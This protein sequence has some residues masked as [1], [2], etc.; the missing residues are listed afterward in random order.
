MIG[1]FGQL[2]EFRMYCARVI[3]RLVYI[4]REIFTNP[5]KSIA[6]FLSELTSRSP[7]LFK[8]V[9]ISSGSDVRPCVS[10]ANVSMSGD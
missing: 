10:A 7:F 5:D 4:V 3:R 2:Y 9:T 6:I 1:R 8:S